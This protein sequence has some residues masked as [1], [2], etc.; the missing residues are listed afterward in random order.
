MHGVLHSLAVP[1]S[2]SMHECEA[3]GSASH[4]LVGSASCSLTCPIPQSATSLGPP[5][6]TLP[7]VLSAPAARL[8]P[9]YRSGWMF[10]LYLLGCWTS[11]Q[12]DFLSV[13]VV[14]CF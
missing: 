7:R 9:S 4:H 1:P 6:A 3:A 13:L 11:I 5:A 14:F 8:H 2:L 12:F 10:L